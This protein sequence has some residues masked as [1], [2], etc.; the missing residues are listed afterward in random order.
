MLQYYISI[1]IF[2][3]VVLELFHAG[4]KCD[5]T[6]CPIFAASLWERSNK[7]C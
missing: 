4:Q 1:Q 3:S 5:Y 2:F 7:A 6:E